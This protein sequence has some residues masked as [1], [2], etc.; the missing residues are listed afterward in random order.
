[1]NQ[2]FMFTEDYFH[3]GD[4]EDALKDTYDQFN[5]LIIPAHKKEAKFYY[6]QC[7]RVPVGIF[8]NPMKVR[9]IMEP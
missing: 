4:W 6:P 8:P 2:R 9:E 7:R 5:L 3:Y 1:M